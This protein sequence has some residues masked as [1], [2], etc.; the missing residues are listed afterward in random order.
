MHFHFGLEALAN[1]GSHLFCIFHAND[2]VT[3]REKNPIDNAILISDTIHTFTRKERGIINFQL[4]IDLSI[5]NL[6]DATS[7]KRAHTTVKK[8]GNAPRLMNS[9]YE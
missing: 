3:F 4:F 8:C 5:P 1:V 9:N 2:Y 7:K 6:I